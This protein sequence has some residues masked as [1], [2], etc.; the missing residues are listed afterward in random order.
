M[1]K[2]RNERPEKKR[3]PRGKKVEMTR[4][5]LLDAAIR[6][7]GSAGYSGVTVRK[8]TSRADLAHGTFY[9]Y[10]RSDQELFD[11]LL[12]HLGQQLFEY[13]DSRLEGAGSFLDNQ[14]MIL[15]ATDE[16]I[17]DTPAFYRVMTEAEAFAP[18]AFRVYINNMVEWF[19]RNLY[20]DESAKPLQMM[21]RQKLESLLLMVVASNHYLNMRFGEW[22]EDLPSVPGWAVETFG[23]FVRGGMLAA[24]GQT[25]PQAVPASAA[26]PSENG[27]AAPNIENPY[28]KFTPRKSGKSEPTPHSAQTMQMDC[29]VK[30]VGPGHVRVELE[31]DRRTLNSRSAVS[32][33]TLSALAEVAAGLAVSH[34]D[35]AKLVGETVNITSTIIQAAT[36]GMLLADA[37]VEN[38]GRNVRFVTVRITLDT[39]SGPVVANA[40]VIM[41]V[42]D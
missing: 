10:F 33:G 26:P 20:A 7:V 24:A 34:D 3:V 17:R 19:I 37:R 5:R 39:L 4:Q 23:Q 11:Q 12:P 29:R 32:G 15:V 1:D 18:R 28:V 35:T 8:V 40:S 16:F 6:V 21:D 13:L 31:I 25:S 42:I 38:A 14:E 41:R 36:E 22:M 2:A 27:P 30:G 9:N